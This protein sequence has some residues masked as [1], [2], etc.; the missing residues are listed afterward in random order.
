M[1]FMQSEPIDELF[2]VRFIQQL[3]HAVSLVG[4]VGTRGVFVEEA[5]ME[6]V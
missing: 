3:I 5:T 2:P 4:V 6:D 1:E